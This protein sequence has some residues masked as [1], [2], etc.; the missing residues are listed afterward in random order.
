[1]MR[2]LWSFIGHVWGRS[3]RASAQPSDSMNLFKLI[4]I[5]GAKVGCIRA[6]Q[7]V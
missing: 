2:G 1:M 4:S 5:F 6:R 3:L 7:Q